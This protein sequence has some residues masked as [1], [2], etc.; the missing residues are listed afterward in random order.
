MKP[1]AHTTTRGWPAILLSGLLACQD[2]QASDRVLRVV[3]SSGRPPFSFHDAKLGDTGIEVDLMR[4]ALQRLGYAMKTAIVPNSR[5]LLAVAGGQA[6]I[7][8]AV[9]EHGADEK[10]LYYS[11][12][13]IEYH[14]VAIGKQDRRLD[15]RSQLDLS[16][17]SFAI[18]QHG[19]RDLGPTFQAIYQPDPSGRFRYNYHETASQE[20]QCRMFWANRVELLII[21]RT[22]FSW[23]RDKLASS[24]PTDAAVTYY[25]IFPQNTAFPAA[26]R[27]KTLRDRFNQA[28]RQLRQS[29]DYPRILARYRLGG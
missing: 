5:L 16:G 4:A 10:G 28:L 23:F 11:D 22:V 1:L 25:D 12:N 29:G 8:S 27:D 2:A 9:H 17:H 7:A 6:D 24:L 15:I 26:F 3:F 14:N 20:N 19:W 18:W 13:F 21:D